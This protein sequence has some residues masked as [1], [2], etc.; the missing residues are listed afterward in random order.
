MQPMQRPAGKQLVT[1]KANY[2]Y[3]EETGEDRA[4]KA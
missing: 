3:N 1:I 2:G 4:L